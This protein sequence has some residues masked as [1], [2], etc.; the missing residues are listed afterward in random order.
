VFKFYVTLKML[1]SNSEG[2]FYKLTHAALKG[3]T[4]KATFVTKYTYKK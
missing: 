4:E 1:I 2:I 3:C